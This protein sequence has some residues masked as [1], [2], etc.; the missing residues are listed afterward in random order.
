[1]CSTTTKE[2][3]N[4]F[5]VWWVQE[6]RRWLPLKKSFVIFTD[7]K[8]RGHHREA[9]VS[10]SLCCASHG[11]EQRSFEKMV[12]LASLSNFSGLCGTGVV[13]SCLVLGQLGQADSSPECERW[14]G[15]RTGLVSLLMKGVINGF[16]LLG[17][18]NPGRGSP[19][20]GSKISRCQSSKKYRKFTWGLEDWRGAEV[21]HC[22]SMWQ[23]ADV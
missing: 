13:P 18:A 6:V 23:K 4:F 14:L 17:L 12:W 2:N 1:M 8:K 7:F 10:K 9:P 16:L 20:W 21:R 11:R 22:S 3:P 15:L 19:S 5:Q